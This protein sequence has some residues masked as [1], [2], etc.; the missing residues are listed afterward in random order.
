MI[1]PSILTSA[2]LFTRNLYECHKKPLS[3]AYATAVAQFRALRAEHSIMTK[4][5]VMEAEHLGA[6]FSK[7]EIEHSFEKE[8]RNLATFE[9]REELDEGAIAARKRWKAIVE[10]T[11]GVKDWSKGQEYV[12]LWKEGIR[13]SYAPLLTQPIE[14]ELP[15][16]ADP[17]AIRASISKKPQYRAARVRR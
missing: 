7:G 16:E 9:R 6:I 11:E 4:F 5:A 2:I 12:K 13:P 3:E 8:K 15:T 14:S 17:I 1:D 10:K